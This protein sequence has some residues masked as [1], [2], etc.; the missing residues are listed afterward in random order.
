MEWGLLKQRCVNV[1]VFDHVRKDIIE[2]NY[3][4]GN[5]TEYKIWTLS[6]LTLTFVCVLSSQCVSHFN[7]CE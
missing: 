1:Y 2:K 5:Y 6:V 7:L 4:F 3:L